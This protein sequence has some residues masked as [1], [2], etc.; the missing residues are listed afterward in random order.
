MSLVGFPGRLHRLLM[1]H[2]L[3]NHRISLRRTE[4][5]RIHEVFV[6]HRDGLL[7]IHITTEEIRD[8]SLLSDSGQKV[9]QIALIFQ[10][11]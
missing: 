3:I 2:L 6:R 7:R 8:P 10:M 5:F 11:L 4:P 1:S 9:R